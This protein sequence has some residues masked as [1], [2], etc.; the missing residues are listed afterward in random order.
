MPQSF[1]DVAHV[2]DRVVD[3]TRAPETCEDHQVRRRVADVE[4]RAR[5]DERH[6]DGDAHDDRAPLEEHEREHEHQKDAADR[7][8]ATGVRRASMVGRPEQRRVDLMPV[9]RAPG[10]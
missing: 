4:H 7:Q 2:D 5:H 10:R 3:P 8:R 9:S 6:R 1:P